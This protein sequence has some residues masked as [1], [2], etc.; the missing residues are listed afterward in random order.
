M[1]GPFPLGELD[2]GHRGDGL[3]G[4]DDALGLA[5]GTA[6][7]GE[8][9]DVVGGQVG[10]DQRLRLVL[11][12]LGGQ[13]LRDTVE[14]LGDGADGEHLRQRGHLLQ[15]AQGPLHEGGRGVDDQRADLGVGQHVGV[16]VQRA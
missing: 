5:G 7:V 14:R 8:P 1:L 6:G 15:Q 9:A 2:G 13:V 11:G 16:V 10:G 3:H 4:A 12:G